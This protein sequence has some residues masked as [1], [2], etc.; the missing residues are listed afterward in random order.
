M[1]SQPSLELG[2]HFRRLARLRFQDQVRYL[3]VRFRD[4]IDGLIGYKLRRNYKW[5]LS[6]LSLGAGWTLP[7]SVRSYYI[8]EIYKLA[9][10]SYKP[11]IFP[12]RAVYFKSTNQSSYHRDSWQT[13]MKDGLEIYEVPAESHMD[14]IKKEN[15]PA[16][17]GPLASCIARAQSTTASLSPEERRAS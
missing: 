2:S 8:L 12:G 13:L 15:V 7:A 10:Q 6:K 1:P 5:M 9:R 4:K 17:A 16:W 11:Q 3:H 14:V